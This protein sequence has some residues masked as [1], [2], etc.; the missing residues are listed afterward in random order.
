[1]PTRSVDQNQDDLKQHHIQKW[2]TLRLYI[3]FL[4]KRSASHFYT[5]Q[6]SKTYF[7][8]TS[9]LITENEFGHTAT[10]DPQLVSWG[11]NVT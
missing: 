2:F 8:I 1:M 5:C 9:S 10:H 3:P 7:L 11:P 4:I 6:I